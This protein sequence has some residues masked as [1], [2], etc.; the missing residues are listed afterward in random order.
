MALADESGWLAAWQLRQLLD[1]KELSA[2]EVVAGCLGRI[3]ALDPSLRSF[4]SVAGERALEEAADADR[5]ARSGPPLGAL[6]GIPVAVKD[7]A[8]TGGIPSTGGSLLYQDFVP[9]EDGEVA[10]RLRRAGAVIVGKTNMPEFAAF[11][12]SK[13][14]LVGESVNPYDTGRTS[15]ASSGGSAAA[16]AAGMVP[17]A[18]GSDG[19]GSIRIPASLCGVVGLYP[20]VGRVPDRGSYS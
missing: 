2:A 12:R 16:L 11:P 4:I 13:T 7:E 14:R 17:S 3:E 10:G 6:D 9:D 19:G 20:T 15:G 18:I 8:W 5:R 1:R